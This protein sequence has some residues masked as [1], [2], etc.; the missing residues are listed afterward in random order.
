V[1]QDDH[2]WIRSYFHGPRG[3]AALLSET[4]QLGKAKMP[5]VASV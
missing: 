1:L 4:G 2:P 5:T 3:R